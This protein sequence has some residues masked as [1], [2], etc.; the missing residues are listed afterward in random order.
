MVI[1]IIAPSRLLRLFVVKEFLWV[2]SAPCATR[3]DL[4]CSLGWQS[5]RDVCAPW[6]GTQKSAGL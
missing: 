4:C 3:A 5:G 1:I 6:K 2:Y